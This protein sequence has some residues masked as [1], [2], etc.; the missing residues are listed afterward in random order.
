MHAARHCWNNHA[1]FES[2]SLFDVKFGKDMSKDIRTINLTLAL[3]PRQLG[4]QKATITKKL[5]ELK[6]QNVPEIGGVLLSWSDLQIINDKGI[7]IDDQPFVFWKVT[8]I[9]HVF[10]MAL[11]KVVKGNIEKIDETY[12]IAKAYDAFKV[13]VSISEEHIENS[14]TKSLAMSGEVYFRMTNV[15]AG[16]YRGILDAECLSLT[17]EDRKNR[18]TEDNFFDYAQ[19]DFQY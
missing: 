15:I 6:L 2:C 12:F 19:D 3:A 5:D 1:W 14:L 10:A 18:G 9:G 13:T 17:E 7:I 11:G 4:D 16:A 8:F